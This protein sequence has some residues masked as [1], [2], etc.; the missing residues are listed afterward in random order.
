MLLAQSGSMEA[1]NQ[2]AKQPRV[3]KLATEGT[4]NPQIVVDALGILVSI[5]QSARELFDV[6]ASD[7]GR[8]LRRLEVSSKPIDLRT[9]L[10]RVF[11]DG[12]PTSLKA[13]EH[14]RIDGSP[15]TL[16]LSV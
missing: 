12:R 4:P 8:A 16:D 6:P 1:T 2:V 11:R 5:N 15:A 10:H 7:L 3:R 9:P 14:Q 13:I